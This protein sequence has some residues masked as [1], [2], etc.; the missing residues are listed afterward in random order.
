MT[1]SLLVLV[2]SMDGRAEL[3]GSVTGQPT[4][5]GVAIPKVMAVWLDKPISIINSDQGYISVVFSRQ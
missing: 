5:F 4:T 2:F 3:T 1:L